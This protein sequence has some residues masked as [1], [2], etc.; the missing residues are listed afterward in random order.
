[1]YKQKYI[2]YKNKYLFTKMI[3][4]GGNNNIVK[5]IKK[6]SI[7]D[8]KT[9]LP[10]ILFNDNYCDK[11]IGRGMMGEVYASSIGKTL[12]VNINNS[13]IN[14][15]VVIKKAIGDGTFDMTI[16]DDILY[17]YS[18]KNLT[19]EA[20]ILEYISEL[21]KK[22]VSPHL[23]FMIGFSRC[24]ENKKPNIDR[25]ITER[26]GLNDE[27]TVEINGIDVSPLFHHDPNYNFD[28][29]SYQTLFTTMFDLFK[30]ILMKE[31]NGS[32][33]LPNNKKC[34]VAKLCD[35]LAISYLHTSGILHTQNISLSDMHMKNVF[36]HWLNDK[37]Y[38]GTRNI[39]NINYIIYDIGSG[40][41]LKMK[42]YGLLLKIGDVGASIVN[43]KDNVIIL[44][45]AV[46]LEKTKHLIKYVT[47]PKLDIGF[48][49]YFKNMLP[50]NIYQKTFISKI[51]S[52]YPYSN[53]ALGKIPYELL[54]A[55]EEPM[56][57]LKK[58][59]R[60]IVSNPI[61]TSDTLII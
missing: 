24:D 18:Y 9:K 17:I 48:F 36:I 42:T 54:D 61:K 57:I 56:E 6:S 41:Y 26:H 13:I 1:M 55:M 59:T 14:I 2:K 16:Y 47:D 35:Y 33:I 34:N 31:K 4:Q 19:T 38:M 29:P 60:Y 49:Y 40:I 20:I 15:P 7:H 28:M 3:Q 51:L 21:W 39:G 30:Y 5:F 27:I 50:P 32:I 23:P 58:F 8:I 44:G 52:V 53:L 46:D 37:S 45:Q 12:D 25:I 11:I 43:P 10:A 22:E